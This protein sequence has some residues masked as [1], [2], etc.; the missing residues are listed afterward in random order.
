ANQVSFQV[1]PRVFDERF[2][3]TVL[4][5]ND[6]SA[7]GT[8]WHGVFLA[9]A[10]DENSSRL[11]L[12]ENAIVIAEPQLGKLELH[13]EGG[14]THEF[15]RQDLNHYGVTRFGKSALPI[16]VT[17]LLPSKQR[18]MSNQE[19]S[20]A[21]LPADKSAGWREAR[22]ELHRRIAFPFACLF[23]ALVAV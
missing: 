18:T 20:L 15:N 23:F 4:Y 3:K 14:A 19:R 6:V 12:A 5:V 17:G 9:E 11:T 16:E 21:D 10:G 7:S 13:L 2:P 1:Q 8:E 22:V